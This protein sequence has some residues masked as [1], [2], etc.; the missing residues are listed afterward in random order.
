MFQNGCGGD[1]DGDGQ[2]DRRTR[3]IERLRKIK[4]EKEAQVRRKE[5][6]VR[7]L[8]VREG[9]IYT[10]ISWLGASELDPYYFSSSSMNILLLFIKSG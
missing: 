6:E 8:R 10:C 5:E 1:G 7:I 4:K 2:D 3:D 9:L